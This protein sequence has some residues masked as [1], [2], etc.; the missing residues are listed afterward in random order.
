MYIYIYIFVYAFIQVIYIPHSIHD[1]K[2]VKAKEGSRG[3]RSSLYSSTGNCR[4]TMERGAV[5]A[6]TLVLS[7]RY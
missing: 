2:P 1:I 3:G 6:A 4:A 5:N 7:I